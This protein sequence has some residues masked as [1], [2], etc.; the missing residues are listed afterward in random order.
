MRH[1]FVSLQAKETEMA[2][3][4]I[5]FAAPLQGFT[6]AVWRN[7][8]DAVFGGVDGY[9]AP[10]I[11]MEHGSVRRRDLNDLL[12]E[13]NTAHMLPQI[14]A[15]RPSDA[16]IMATTLRDMGLGQVDI[17][18]GCPHPPIALKHKGCGMMA[19]PEEVEAMCQALSRVS[20]TCYTVK[21]RLGWNH[22]GQWH[23]VLTAL[24]AIH[25]QHITIHP[26]I[27]TQQYKGDLL[28]DEFER[29]L[30]QSPYPVVYNGGI[31]SITHIE[32]V[33]QHYQ[34][35]KG[36]MIGRA[37]ISNPS[38]LNPDSYDSEHYTAFHQALVEGYTRQLLG[39]EHQL[40]T[41]LKSLWG[42]WLPNADHRLRKQV[43]KARNMNQ[44]LCAANAVFANLPMA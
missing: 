19:H 2:T 28:L 21:M 20:G 29:L 7:A 11:R 42:L 5:V 44:Y 33:H 36:V 17:N 26:R 43:A 23:D 10:F 25:P 8:H 34:G 41:R 39:G 22:P 27:G 38:L 12:E 24:A 15:T 18:L 32:E 13:R 3:S 4:R 40:L 6:D 30:A 16:V 31:S 14:L 37:L 1:F 9:Y 35:L